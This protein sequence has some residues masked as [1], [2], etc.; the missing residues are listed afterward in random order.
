MAAHLIGPGSD[1][2]IAVLFNDMQTERYKGKLVEPRDYPGLW[3]N[4]DDARLTEDNVQSFFDQTLIYQ[5]AEG[6]EGR[7]GIRRAVTRA[8][9]LQQGEGFFRTDASLNLVLITNEDDFPSPDNAEFVDTLITSE[10]SLSEVHVYAVTQTDSIGCLAPYTPAEPAAS[11]LDLVDLTGGFSES[12]CR[13]DWTGFLSSVGQAIASDALRHTFTLSEPAKLEGLTV[14]VDPPDGPPYPW[15]DWSLQ[16]EYT[17]VFPDA[18]PPLGS[19][20]LVDYVH[21]WRH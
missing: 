6:P 2:R 5:Q 17:L 4:G 11:I 9:A 15:D 14:Q 3:L 13:L 1:T 7:Y 12:V 10:G 8:L 21:D 16:D 20:I 18:A 19:T